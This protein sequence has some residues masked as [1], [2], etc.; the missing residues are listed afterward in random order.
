MELGSESRF[1]ALVLFHRYARRFYR[2]VVLP[3]QHQPKKQQHHQRG[4]L[5]Q[6]QRQQQSTSQ[7][8]QQLFVA[9]QEERDR[10]KNHL[11]PVA[12]VR[13]FLGCKIEEEPQ[14]IRDVIN[15]SHLLIFHVR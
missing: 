8:G 2:L 15:L 1:T 11:G 5:Q 12:A 10:I 14:Q 13:L 4:Q 6:Q 3:Q 7:E 9:A